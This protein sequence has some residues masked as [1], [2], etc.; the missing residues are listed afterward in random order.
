MAS[1]KPYDDLLKNKLET[2]NEVVNMIVCY[3]LIIFS[4]A[5]DDQDSKEYTSFIIMGIIFTNIFFN[6]LALLIQFV[7]FLRRKFRIWKRYF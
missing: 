7:K 4:E 1:F 6:I 5:Y 3:S 2:I